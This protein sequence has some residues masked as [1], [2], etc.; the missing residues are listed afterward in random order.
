MQRDDFPLVVEDRRTR[1]PL[2]GVGLVVQEPLQHVD[3]LVLAERDLLG[4]ASRVLDDV[5]ELPYDGLA[6]RLTEDQPAERRQRLALRTAWGHRDE[7]VVQRPV[8]D[9][10]PERLQLEDRRYERVAVGAV[11]E[12]ERDLAAA[13]LLSVAQDVVVGEEQGGGDHET[14]TVSAPR[15]ADGDPADR[16]RDLDPLLQ[17]CDRGEVVAPDE[18][19]QPQRLTGEALRGQA[20]GAPRTA[21][22]FGRCPLDRP[23]HGPVGAE[24]CQPLLDPLGGVRV[25]HATRLED[26]LVSFTLF[27]AVRIACRGHRQLRQI[28]RLSFRSEV[29]R[30]HDPP[31]GLS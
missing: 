18:A 19:L 14:G 10:A 4:L 8:G 11:L 6:L 15:P 5:D 7:G 23:C 29:R 3:D 27:G 2:T 26:G 21:G 16:A 13:G 22:G 28:V 30:G 17:E 31:P 1:G 25:Q 9:E 24:T 20:Q 12:G